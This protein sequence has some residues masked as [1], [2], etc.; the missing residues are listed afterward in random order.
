MTALIDSGAQ[1]S[2]I[3]RGMAKKMKLKIQKLKRL[4]RIEG[5][6]GGK[7][8]YKGY[9]EV[10]LEVPGLQNL[11]EYIL[12]LVIE[13]SEYGERVPLQLGT[14]HIDMILQKATKEEI[15]KV[16]K[17]FER[18]SVARSILNHKGCFNLDMVKG[19]I[20]VTK[21]ITI[22]LGEM[23]KIN[24]LTNLKGNTKRLQ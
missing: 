21:E 17:A 7:V 22:K 13:D 18:G 10:L 20:K 3:T 16:G 1:I 11:R 8:P 23:I 12:M 24:G 14:L 15:S 19:P 9:V 4:L 5:M 6:G 2:A